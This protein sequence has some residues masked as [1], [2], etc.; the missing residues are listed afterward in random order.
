MPN[1]LADMGV[2]T[3]ANRDTI[4]GANLKEGALGY[5]NPILA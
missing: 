5:V 2:Q 3:P 1:M 4:A